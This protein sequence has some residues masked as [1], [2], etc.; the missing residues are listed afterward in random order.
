MYCR[1][2]WQALKT[3]VVFFWSPKVRAHSYLML[4]VLPLAV[5][6]AKAMALHQK[7]HLLST[8]NW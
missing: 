2:L 6:K 8:F 4:P 7:Q 1:G 5:L 3:A